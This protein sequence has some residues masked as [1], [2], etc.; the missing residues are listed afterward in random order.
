M[1]WDETIYADLVALEAKLAQQLRD[2]SESLHERFKNKEKTWNDGDTNIYMRDQLRHAQLTRELETAR[3]EVGRMRLLDPGL[4]EF[5]TPEDGTLARWM[6]NGKDGLEEW[7]F[8]KHCRDIEDPALKGQINSSRRFVIHG[9]AE[10]HPVKKSPATEDVT[11]SRTVLDDLLAYGAVS[12]ACMQLRTRN[13]NKIEFPRNDDTDVVGVLVEELADVPERGTSYDQLEVDARTMTSQRVVISRQMLTDNIINAPNHIMGLLVRRMG[14]GWN[15]LFTNGDGSKITGVRT[16]ARTGNETAAVDAVTYKEIVKLAYTIPLAYR[17]GSEG[18]EGGFS[19]KTGGMVGFMIAD[20][21]EQL[22]RE[23]LD[24]NGQPLWVPSVRDGAPS[25]FAGWPMMVNA[26]LPNPGASIA[27]SVLFGN[28]AY[29]LVRSV[30][31]IELHRFWDSNTAEKN[32]EHFVGFSR[33]MGIHNGFTVEE[34]RSGEK[35][36]AAKE[37]ARLTQPAS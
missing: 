28:F 15:R 13:G 11:T 19:A 10:T 36:N 27:G 1:K 24:A 35:Y 18:G 21:V 6:K 25:R 30:N 22:F 17:S 32:S 5:R 33:R 16:A 29:Y 2:L 37:S 31:S 26:D 20:G 12:R 9:Q 34:T 14:R 7:E 23:M 4:E 3:A 8:N